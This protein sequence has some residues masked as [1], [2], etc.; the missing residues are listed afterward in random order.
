VG[1]QRGISNVEKKL[2]KLDGRINDHG[3]R[4]RMEESTLPS[5]G[6]KMLIKPRKK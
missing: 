4:G 2:S 1:F 6:W 5:K 3:K